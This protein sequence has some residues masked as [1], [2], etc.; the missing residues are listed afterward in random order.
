MRWILPPKE[1]IEVQV[2]SQIL[3]SG[4]RALDELATNASQLSPVFMDEGVP[5]AR[6]WRH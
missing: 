5:T 3:C 4:S 6:L 2:S 1:G